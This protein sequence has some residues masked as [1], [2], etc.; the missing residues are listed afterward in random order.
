VRRTARRARAVESGPSGE[1]SSDAISD[2]DQGVTGHLIT[3]KVERSPDAFLMR[4]TD[5]GKHGSDGVARPEWY[6]E[7]YG[8]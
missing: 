2:A 7:V 4:I 8:Y 1:K 5:T 6:D 3:T